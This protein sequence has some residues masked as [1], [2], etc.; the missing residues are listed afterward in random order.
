LSR[1]K[2]NFGDHHERP[3]RKIRLAPIVA[4]A[5]RVNE[6]FKRRA[7]ISEAGRYRM[8]PKPKPRVPMKARSAVAES[9]VEP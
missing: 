8:I 3:K 5:D 4:R 6:K 9:R 1:I 7:L 2:I